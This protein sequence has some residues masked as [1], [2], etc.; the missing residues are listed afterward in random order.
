MNA[1]IRYTPDR[2]E[3]VSV[4]ARGKCQS[5]V[6]LNRGRG[7]GTYQTAAHVGRDQNVG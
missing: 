1:Y 7:I 4:L 5:E 6:L 3:A 2:T